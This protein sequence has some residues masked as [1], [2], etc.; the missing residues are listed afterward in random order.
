MGITST[1]KKKYTPEPTLITYSAT[2]LRVTIISPDDDYF[3]PISLPEWEQM[4][5]V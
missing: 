4:V 5:H 2:P 1:G 3:L